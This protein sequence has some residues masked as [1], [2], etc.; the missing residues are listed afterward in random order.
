[1]WKKNVPWLRPPYRRGV[2]IAP[3]GDPRSSC[4]FH[5]CTWIMHYLYHTSNNLVNQ[6]TSTCIDKKVNRPNK[7]EK[8]K[9]TKRERK[10][11]KE[12]YCMMLIE[13]VPKPRTFVAQRF[14]FASSLP[15]V[16]PRTAGHA[17]CRHQSERRRGLPP[18][19]GGRA[20]RRINA[21]RFGGTETRAAVD[22]KCFLFYSSWLLLRETCRNG[23]IKSNSDKPRQ[24]CS[25]IK[26]IPMETIHITY[27]CWKKTT[28]RERTKWTP[29]LWLNSFI[30][31]T[32]KKIEKRKKLTAPP[33]LLPAP[34]P[35]PLPWPA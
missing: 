27:D 35:R 11:R 19:R 23:V 10:K 20:R 26:I 8:R 1:M 14:L 34:T 16:P 29:L 12:M 28:K 30:K 22:F 25:N 31:W 18:V 9:H 2:W 4:A 7:I 21:R 33:A 17:R 15:P 24:P 13:S 32:H 3:H 6:S 5:T